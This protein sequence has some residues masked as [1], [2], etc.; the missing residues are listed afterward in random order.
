MGLFP[1][2]VEVIEAVCDFDERK[3]GADGGS[4][5]GRALSGVTQKRGFPGGWMGGMSA[6]GAG[7]GGETESVWMIGAERR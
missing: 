4:R 7:D 2:E 3:A 1:F 6:G 5:R